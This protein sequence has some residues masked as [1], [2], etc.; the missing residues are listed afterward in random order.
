M[1]LLNYE[2]N[3][4]GLADYHFNGF[5]NDTVTFYIKTKALLHIRIRNVST[6]SFSYFS[7][8]WQEIKLTKSTITLENYTLK[9]LK[10]LYALMCYISYY[11]K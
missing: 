7:R 1:L 9:P 11:I 2:I 4:W 5:V 3:F 6:F 10:K 8:K